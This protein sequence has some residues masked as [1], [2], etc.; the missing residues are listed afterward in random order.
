MPDLLACKRIRLGGYVV[1]VS[2]ATA[3]ESFVLDTV[4]LARTRSRLRG[5]VAIVAIASKA[6]NLQYALSH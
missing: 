3:A 6:M 2:V 5:C 4:V 1:I